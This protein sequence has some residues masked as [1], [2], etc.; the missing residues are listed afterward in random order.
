MSNIV[1]R[2]RSGTLARV[3]EGA[4]AAGPMVVA[5]VR[6]LLRSGA[7]ERAIQRGVEA[8]S[9]FIAD[10]VSTQGLRSGPRAVTRFQSSTPAN[11]AARLAARRRTSP[12]RPN[13]I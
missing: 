7:Q 5:G 13:N 3:V 9:G 1:L 12:R 11:N 2:N 4:T 8:A 6:N 10:E